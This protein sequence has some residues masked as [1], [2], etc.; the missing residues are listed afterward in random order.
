MKP[1]KSYIILKIFGFLIFSIGILYICQFFTKTLEEGFSKS[2]EGFAIPSQCS[3][4]T[5]AGR[6]IILCPSE[7]YASIIFADMSNNLPGKYDNL[8]IGSGEFGTD[9]Y[10]CYTRPGPKVYNCMNY[11]IYRDF[12]PT[13]DNDTMP[14]DLIP[15]IDT[16]CASYPT[17]TLKV[18]RGITSTTAVLNVINNTLT[19]TTQYKNEIGLLQ[20]LCSSAAPE[21]NGPCSNINTAFQSLNSMTA[22]QQLATAQTAVRTSLNSLSNISTQMYS[23]YNGSKCE[24]LPQYAMSNGRS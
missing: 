6:K 21:I 17:N 4:I 13:V 7:E 8:C 22:A 3:E 18:N 10:T 2:V 12:D 5:N 1:N 20:T 15:S 24:S 14:S 19:S 16:F 23:I 11:G 9:Y